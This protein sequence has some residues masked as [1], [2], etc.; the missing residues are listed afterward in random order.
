MYFVSFVKLILLLGY[1]S[2]SR[3]S[4]SVQLVGNSLYVFARSFTNSSLLFVSTLDYSSML[5][6]PWRIVGGESTPLMTDASVAYNSFTQVSY[7]ANTTP[8]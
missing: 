1:E 2:S 7:H 4:I 5:S 3:D 8:K 6:T